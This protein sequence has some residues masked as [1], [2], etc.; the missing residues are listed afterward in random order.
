MLNVIYNEDC[1]T[2]IKK[3]PDKTVD[4]VITDPPYKINNHC[5]GGK[6]I[7]SDNLNKYNA[8]LYKNK[9]TQGYN[10]KI[11]DELLRVMKKIN[12]CTIKCGGKLLSF[13]YID[14]QNRNT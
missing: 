10:Y 1:L 2:G 9:L 12:I 4:L 8:E 7:L 6:T 3:I 14:K 5:A 11:L 13:L